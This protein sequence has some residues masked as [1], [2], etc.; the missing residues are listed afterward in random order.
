MPGEPR[1][2]RLHP[3]WVKRDDCD[4]RASQLTSS[5]HRELIQGGFGHPIGPI[6]TATI[7]LRRSLLVFVA[8]VRLS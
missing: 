8:S 4:T 7:V 5:V 1:H 3:A 6:A 2:L